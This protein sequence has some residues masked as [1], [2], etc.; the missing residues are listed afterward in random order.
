[1]NL[2]HCQIVNCINTGLCVEPMCTG[3]QKT[4]NYWTMCSTDVYRASKNTHHL[5]KSFDVK[6]K[7]LMMSVWWQEEKPAFPPPPSPFPF[8]SPSLPVPSLF[9]PP[10]KSSGAEPHWKSNLV[11]FSLKIWHLMAP[12]LL[13]FLRI[14]L[15]QC[16]HCFQLCFC[17]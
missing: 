7:T 5:S 12:V 17:T 11:H 3:L 16:M 13:I 6:L 14:N 9:L 15:P 4:H 1:M 2:S 10:S 8:S